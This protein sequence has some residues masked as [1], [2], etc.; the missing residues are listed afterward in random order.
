MMYAGLDL[1]RRRLNVHVLDEDGR[2]VQVTA[3]S[4]MPADSGHSPPTS[5]AS[6]TR[7]TPR[8]SR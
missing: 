8:S 5:C 4:P 3:V 6:A 7:C 2:T 1:S